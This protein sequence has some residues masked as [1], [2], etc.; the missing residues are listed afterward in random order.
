METMENRWPY[1]LPW[2]VE[3]RM[4]IRYFIGRGI[5]YGHTE[6]Y[7]PWKIIWP[8]GTPRA[9]EYCMARDFRMTGEFHMTGNFTK[10]K[11]TDWSDKGKVM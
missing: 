9:G 3:F 5:P 1:G 2:S 10:Y 6:F 4:A 11:I 7:G 8:Y